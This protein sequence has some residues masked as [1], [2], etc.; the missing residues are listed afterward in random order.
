MWNYL[1]ARWQSLIFRLLF[2]FFISILALAVILAISFAQ[3]LKPH[4]E[5]VAAGVNFAQ[6]IALQNLVPNCDPGIC[7][8]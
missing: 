4:V 1:Q 6:T 2:Y 8:F 7:T 5:N 3:R